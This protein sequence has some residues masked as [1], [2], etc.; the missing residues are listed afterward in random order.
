MTGQN[1]YPGVY[2]TED[3]QMAKALTATAVDRY[4]TTDQRQEIPDGATPGLRLIIQPNG[5]KSWAMR[6]R[7]PNGSQAKLFLGPYDDATEEL[8]QSPAIGQ[9]L[10]LV[11]ARAL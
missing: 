9:P 6:F 4:K 5:S 10:T 1:V 7:R 11:A 3:E 2:P 8:D